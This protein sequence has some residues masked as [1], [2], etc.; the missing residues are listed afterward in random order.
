MKHLER[1]L[2]GQ[3]NFWK[4]LCN[5]VA[6]L[7]GGSMIGS[8]PLMILIAVKT[9]Q[10]NGA[11]A[12]NPANALDFTAYGIS[13]NLGLARNTTFRQAPVTCLTVFVK[14]PTR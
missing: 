6:S 8:I 13:L 2:D 11:I 3:N 4:Y 1:A 9:I 7:L 10:N 5:F 14:W 12:P